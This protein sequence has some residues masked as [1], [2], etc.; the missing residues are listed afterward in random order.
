[1]EPTNETVMQANGVYPARL[2]T[3]QKTDCERRLVTDGGAD[4]TRKLSNSGK[5]N[6]PP[7]LRAR[8]FLIFEPGA[9]Q[10]VPED[11]I[12]L[13]PERDPPSLYG[14]LEGEVRRGHMTTDGQLTLPTP[15]REESGLTSDMQIDIFVEDD[16]RIRLAKHEP[17]D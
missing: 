7:E 4:Y 12:H 15:F 6:F 5:I 9:T 8:R 3:Y 17:E 13:Y 14:P 16:G 10:S 1:M 11:E 2:H